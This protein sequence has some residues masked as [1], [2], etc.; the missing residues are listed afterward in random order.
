MNAIFALVFFAAIQLAPEPADVIHVQ[1]PLGETLS[2]IRD[3]EGWWTVVR[4]G[5]A[6]ERKVRTEDGRLVSRPVDRGAEETVDMPEVDWS[7]AEAFERDGVRFLV[8]RQAQGATITWLAADDLRRVF[9]LNWARDERL[10][11]IPAEA[12]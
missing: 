5:V 7:E 6:P 4:D 9:R 12:P 10:P 11:G 3:R 8:E 1:T 2:L